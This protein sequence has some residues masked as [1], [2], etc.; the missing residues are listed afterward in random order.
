MSIH[1]E[2]WKAMGSEKIRKGQK[3]EVIEVDGLVLT[4]RKLE[5]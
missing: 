3:V 2:V 5:K 4:V 1:G